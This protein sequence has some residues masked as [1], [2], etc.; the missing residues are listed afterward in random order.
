M[1]IRAWFERQR[2]WRQDHTAAFAAVTEMHADGLTVFQHNAI[3]AVS[4]FIG[5]EKFDRIA[6][7]DDDGEC[8]T[9]P[10]GTDGAVLWIYT[11]DA[12]I[13]G[14]KPYSSFEEWD[15]ERPKIF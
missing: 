10:L 8:L 9:A 5:P 14:V 3:A 15:Y 13:F 2:R 12:G 6:M 4:S 11:N 1:G 7:R